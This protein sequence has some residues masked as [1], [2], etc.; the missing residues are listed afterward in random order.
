MTSYPNA[1]RD[2]SKSQRSLD[3]IATIPS[4]LVLLGL[5]SPLIRHVAESDEP[6][7][8]ENTWTKTIVDEGAIGWLVTRGDQFN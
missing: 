1:K 8:D 2:E 6:E 4:V 7:K 3:T 5:L